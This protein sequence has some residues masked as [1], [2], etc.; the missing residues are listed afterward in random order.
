MSRIKVLTFQSKEVIQTL[1]DSGIYLSD[2]NKSR[3]GRDY[4][5]DIKQLGGYHPVWCFVHIDRK[6]FKIEDFLNGDLF[7]RY[8]CEMSLNSDKGL[9]E[10]FLLELEVDKESMKLGLTHNAYRGAIVIPFIKIE[11]LCAIYTLN[12]NDWYYANV[13]LVS[14]FKLD[15]LF[16]GGLECMKVEA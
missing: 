10:F 1:L 5:L 6:D 11:Q 4:H 9:S 3:E 7:F 16:P 12:Y 14:R 2:P 15:I 8:K 13:Q